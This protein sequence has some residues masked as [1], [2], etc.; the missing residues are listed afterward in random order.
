[1]LLLLPFKLS[2]SSTA[3]A[4]R[5]IDR[6]KLDKDA[7]SSPPPPP[8]LD[9]AVVLVEDAN[10]GLW[11]NEL[12]EFINFASLTR[13]FRSDIIPDRVD[14]DMILYIIDMVITKRFINICRSI[15]RL[16]ELRAFKVLL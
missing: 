9:D 1:M 10:K 5:A 8:P 7:L 12:L 16:L 15:N 2:L 3:R 4:T 11:S 6:L 14:D 13:L